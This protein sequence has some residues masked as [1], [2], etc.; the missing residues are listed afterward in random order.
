M[1]TIQVTR[2]IT[3]IS[4]LDAELKENNSKYLNLT[5]K[6]DDFNLNYNQ[7][8]SQAE[9]DSIFN[10]INNFVEVSIVDNFGGYLD[11]AI[12]TF[13]RQWINRI[14]AENLALG[15]TTQNGMIQFQSMVELPV[16]LSEVHHVS[17]LGTLTTGTLPLSVMVIRYLK[18]R[19]ELFT[20]PFITLDRLQ[21]WDD[22]IVTFLSTS[23]SR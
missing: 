7:Q 5:A 14:S 15:M 10:L 4:K 13:T 16:A 20:P 12:A 18:T 3:N 19:T 11:R 21:E 22:Q 1:F 8:L 23:R 17:L 2:S 9:V 6:G